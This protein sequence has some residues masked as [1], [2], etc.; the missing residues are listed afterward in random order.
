MDKI[1]YFA[2][3]EGFI[4]GKYRKVGDKIGLTEKQAKYLLLDGTL[5]EKDPKVKAAEKKTPKVGDV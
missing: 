5:S 3:V 4:E 2:A 1:T